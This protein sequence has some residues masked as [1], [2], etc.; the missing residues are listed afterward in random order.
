M[1]STFGSLMFADAPPAAIDGLVPRRLVPPARRGGQD[2]PAGVRVRR[3]HDELALRHHDEPVG[4]RLV[5]GRLERRLGRRARGGHGGDRDRHRRRW[6]HPDPGV[7]LRPGRTQADERRHRSR[8]HPRLDRPLDVR[9]ARRRRSPT[10]GCCCRWR[11]DPSRG[12]LGAAVPAPDAS[13]A[14]HARPRRPSVR[15]HPSP[16]GGVA[17]RFESALASVERDL[18]LPWSCSGPARFS[19][20]GSTGDDWYTLTPSSTSIGS[21]GLRRGNLDRFTPAFA[22]PMRMALRHRP[23][24]TWPPG[25]AASTTSRPRPAARR[26]RRAPHARRCASRGSVRRGP[27]PSSGEEADAYNTGETNITGHPSLSVPAGVCRTVSRSGC[28]SRPAVPR[29]PRP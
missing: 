26:R 4:D 3:V 24:R 12:T 2:E 25:G 11:P 16:P 19:R 15:G 1:P 21:A 22:A 29:R 10:C 27:G 8:S 20:H 7:V 9:P 23:R 28:R 13:G 17:D 5:A 14:A 6:L 18:G